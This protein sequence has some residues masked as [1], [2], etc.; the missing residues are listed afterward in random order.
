MSILSDETIAS[1]IREAKTVPTGLSPLGKL[2]ARNQH[3]RREYDVIAKSG[4]PFTV[5]I[6]QSDLNIMDFSVVL[7]YRL[8]QVHTVFRLRRYNGKHQH[9]NVLEK[10]T[11]YDFHV[12]TATRRYQTPGFKEDHFAETTTR[13]WNLESAIQSLIADCGFRTFEDT[14]LFGGAE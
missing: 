13:H 9:T 6:R 14:P 5:F 3:K 7:G 12:H 8:P 2:V 11:F 1:L 4:N 10:Q